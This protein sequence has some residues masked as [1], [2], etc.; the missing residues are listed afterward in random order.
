MI[1]FILYIFSI[2]LYNQTTS[3]QKVKPLLV[4]SF[5]GLRADKFD[6][7]ISKNP[8]SAFATFA[9]SGAKSEYMQPSFPSSTYPNHMTLVTGK[10]IILHK[11]PSSIFLLNSSSKSWKE[12]SLFLFNKR[13]VKLFRTFE[14]NADSYMFKVYTRNRTVLF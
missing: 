4:V 11:I 14:W 8:K 5:D 3:V 2:I 10:F 1:F 9:K 6:D 13:Y 7:F 12:S